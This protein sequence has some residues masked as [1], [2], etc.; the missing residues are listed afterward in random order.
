M[1]RRF[2]TFTQ[3]SCLSKAELDLRKRQAPEKRPGTS[4]VRV[5]APRLLT[6][7]G[8]P[9]A[10]PPSGEK[11]RRDTW[12]EIR[13][14]RGLRGE[15]RSASKNSIP[16]EKDWE[17]GLFEGLGSRTGKKASKKDSLRASLRQTFD[18]A[19]RDYLAP[20]FSTE[21]GEALIIE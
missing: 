4:D 7:C 16:G 15:S 3:E 9:S 17:E 8:R 13:A 12:K 11:V 6:S 10:F 2:E 21:A 5:G 1:L 19:D 20:T 18:L 14:E